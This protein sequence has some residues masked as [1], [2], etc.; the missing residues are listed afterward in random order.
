MDEQ[1]HRGPVRVGEVVGG[2]DDAT[3]AGDV[4]ITVPVTCHDRL[5]RPGEEHL[6]RA[7]NGRRVV[8]VPA[9]AHLRR[10]PSLRL[11]SLPVPAPNPASRCWPG[12]T[13]PRWPWRWPRTPSRPRWPAPSW[14][15]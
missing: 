2:H 11:A 1:G 13:G 12:R 10:L 8:L 9:I 5:D 4:L 7:A 15:G 6:G 14:A 3:G